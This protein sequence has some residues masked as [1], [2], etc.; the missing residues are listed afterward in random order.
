MKLYNEVFHFLY[1]RIRRV[2]ALCIWVIILLV[3]IYLSRVLDNVD[4]M[5]VN[6]SSFGEKKNARRRL[7]QIIIVIINIAKHI[8]SETTAQCQAIC[9]CII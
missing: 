9:H 7:H 3:C 6:M 8:N 5:K 1:K 4:E 2:S